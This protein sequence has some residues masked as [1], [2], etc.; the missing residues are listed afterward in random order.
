MQNSKDGSRRSAQLA[1]RMP[2]RSCAPAWSSRGPPPRR[3]I[4]RRRRRYKVRPLPPSHRPSFPASCQPGA[5]LNFL[6][7]GYYEFNFNN[8]PGRANDLRAYDVLSN[9]ISINQAD[10][11][12]AIDP[13]LEARRRYGMRL[14]LQFGQATETLRQPRKRTAPRNLS[15]HLPGLWQLHR[16]AGRRLE[17]RCGQVGK[18]T[19]R[20]RQLHQGPDELFALVLLLFPAL[21]SRR[22]ARVLSRQ[23]Q[24]RAELLDRERNQSVR[25]DQRLQGRALRLRAHAKDQS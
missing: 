9:V 21:L 19:R 14:D 23:R 4:F 13:D 25:A 24:A 6:F 18:L 1:P 2:R 8:P 17:H 10:L 15:Q 12:F 11:I 3:A 22:R 20:G 5:T 7:D 16:T